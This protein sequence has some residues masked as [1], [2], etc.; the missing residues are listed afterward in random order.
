MAIFL[1][2]QHTDSAWRD[3]VK[4]SKIVGH[5][6]QRYWWDHHNDDPEEKIGGEHRGKRRPSQGDA[7]KIAQLVQRLQ[8]IPLTSG[9]VALSPSQ[10]QAVADLVMWLAGRNAGAF[11][12][13]HRSS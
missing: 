9:S 8:C 12:L 4:A 1:K 5:D 6:K 11:D 2:H 7:V 10:S 13:T 3:L